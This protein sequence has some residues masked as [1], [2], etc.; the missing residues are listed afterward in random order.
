M[1]ANKSTFTS[2]MTLNHM[3]DVSPQVAIKEARGLPAKLSNFVFCQYSFWGEDESVV[4]PPG[5]RPDSPDPEAVTANFTFQH[6]KVC[7]HNKY[8]SE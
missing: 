7:L 1:Y 5:G 3:F 8:I 4:V 6:E 2:T